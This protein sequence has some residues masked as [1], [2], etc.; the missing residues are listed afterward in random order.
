[1]QVVRPPGLHLRVG[2]M[3]AR[4]AVSAAALALLTGLVL[5]FSGQAL[6][7]NAPT[8]SGSNSLSFPEG[9]TTSMV[10]AIYTATDPDMDTLTWS[11]GGVDAGAFTLTRNA[12]NPVRQLKFSEAPDY[13]FP[14]D[15]GGNNVYDITVNVADDETP[16]MTTELP[17]TVTVTNV[18]EAP[19]IKTGTTGAASQENRLATELVAY[20]RAEDP[21]A[22]TTLTWTVEGEDANFFIITKIINTAG[23]NEGELR[24]RVS[25]DFE[26]PEDATG[27]RFYNVTVRVSD[28]SLSDTWMTTIQ[29]TN[30]D[31]PGT[32]TITGALFEGEQLTAAVT[33]IDGAVSNLTWQW[34][35]GDSA[36]GP[37]ADIS[38]ATSDGYTSVAADV[39]SYLRATATYEDPESP[40]ANKTANAVTSGAVEA[41]NSEP[42][43]SS[44]TATRTLP[45]N[46]GA[47]V[48]VVGGTTAATDSDDDTLIYTLTGTD[49]GSFEIDS[50]GQL[51]TRTGISHN[52]NFEAAKNS[53][54]VTVRVHDGKDTFG[55]TDTTIDATIAVTIDLTNVNE[56]PVITTDSGTFA[57]FTVDENTGTSVVIKTY[58]ATDV[59]ASTTLTWSLE[60]TDAGDFAITKNAQGHGELTFASVP[61][62]E[63]AADADDMNDYDIRVKVTD[64]GIPANRG[65]TNQLDDTVS[66]TIEVEDVNEAP[67]IT[68][69]P[70]TRNVPENSTAVGTYTASDVDDSDTRMWSVESDDDGGFFQ[71]NSSGELSFISAPDFEDKQDADGDNVYDVRVTV[72]DSGGL[73]DTEQV[74]VTVTNVNEAPVITTDSGTFAAFTVDENTETSVVIKTYTATDV[75]ASTTLTWSLEG[76]DAGDFAITT[77]A[78]GHG[79]LTFASVPNFEMAADADGLNDYDIRVKVKDNGIPGNRGASNQLDDTVSVTVEVVDVN[80]APTITAGPTTR[81]V[82]ENS[83]AVGTYTAS[84]VDDSDTRMWSLESDDDGGFFQINSSGELSFISAPDFEHK[85][86]ADGDN[87]YDVRVT[88]TDSGGLND[89]EQVAVTVTNVNEAPVITTDSGTFAAFTV[90][91]NTETSVV[92]KTYTATDVDASTTLTWSLEGTDAGDFAITT[93]AQG[94]GELTFAS[95]PNFEMAADADNMNDYDIRVKVTDNGIPANRGATNQLDDTV[96]VAIEV[97]DV[98]E[99]PTI[100]A[101]PTTR[102]VPEN[103]TAVGAYTASDVDDSDTQTWSVESA[104]DGDLFQIN[105]SGELSFISAPDFEDKQDA[106]DNNVYDVTVKVTDSGDLNDTEQVAVTVMNVNEAPVFN[107]DSSLTQQVDENTPVSVNI[108]P[109]IAEDQDAGTDFT[110]SLEGDDSSQFTIRDN[111][112]DWGVVRFRNSPNYELPTDMD[113]DNFYKITYKVQ[114][115]HNPRMEATLD[116]I[117]EVKD[118]NE[119]PVV[120]GDNSPDFPEIEFDV[121]AAGLTAADLTVASAYTA[122]DDDDGDDV[123]WS[124]NGTDADHFV[125]TE[126]ASGNGV[127]T[128][129]NPSPNTNLKPADHENPV[130]MGSGNDYKVIVQARDDDPLSPLTGT[131]NVTVT[132]SNVDETPEITTTGPTYATP[133]FDEIEYDATTA[134]LAVA[135]YDARDEEDE[136]I[137]WSLDGSDAGDLTIDSGTGVLSFRNRP[138][139][140]DPEGTPATPGDDPDNTYEFVVRATDAATPPDN[141]ARNT[142]EFGVTVTVKDIDETPEVTG[143]DDNPSFPETP[144][145]MPDTTPDVATFTAYDEEDQ[146]IT[147]DLGGDDGEDFTITKDPDSGAGVLTFNDPPDYEDPVDFHSLNTYDIIVQASDG[148]N[149]GTW[150]YAVAVTDVNERPEFTGTV[151]TVFVLDEH[152]ANEVYTTTALT[153]YRARDEEGGVTWSLTGTDRLDFIIGG[154][155]GVVTFADTPSFE[156]PADAGGDNVYAFTV[157]ATDVLSGSSRLTAT[158]DVTV[159]VEDVE[160]AGTI[161]VNNL[162]PALGADCDR[163][164]PSDPGDDCVVFSLTDPDGERPLCW[165]RQLH[166]YRSAGTCSSGSKEGQTT[167]MYGPNWGTPN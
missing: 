143:P 95:V 19:E 27:N 3:T 32:V 38:T 71:I 67:T 46:S 126:D 101:G 121:D 153:S 81:N 123:T 74:A 30:V 68:A 17:V 57:A 141:T 31:E 78:Q 104:D 29:V 10:L 79:E 92:I 80:E 56:A 69:G 44:A 107:E 100:T 18:N 53:Y 139:F 73:N 84:D 156:T 105:S 14:A 21:D 137:T 26:M 87:V 63:I 93:N 122:Y 129:K 127:L 72:T 131:F 118:V 25:P 150:D 106:G 125:I 23:E 47:G 163:T 109:Y 130:D 112:N 62:F 155:S 154:E 166:E 24:F 34:A 110:W 49:A 48:N 11:L 119:R 7:Q 64:N 160:E 151:D 42:T 75:D 20:Y 97:E 43:F 50:N 162:N 158:E 88:V 9:T 4:A 58:T 28:G 36:A 140:E 114:D 65:A 52:F 45:E 5:V 159:T 148:T 35:R 77:N 152:D 165:R 55:N 66:V 134:D 149:T 89:T 124:L 59:D 6:A 2:R 76:T 98:N 82:P 138:D 91:E 128:F 15:D 83:T 102:T 115:N 116:V 136:T 12:G 41:G 94:H 1:M 145:D 37:F 39:G 108:E 117:V 13:E 90:G 133:A 157:V 99:A 103:S 144:Y 132:V 146:D 22:L 60:G 120:S 8:I 167:W 54:S 135:D 111:N 61:N 147:W 85:Q 164:N 16:V 40:V 86:D 113:E 33:D 70:T 51:K 161:T 96:S 142:R